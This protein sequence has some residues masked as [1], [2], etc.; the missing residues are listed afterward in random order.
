MKSLLVLQL[1]TE[2]EEL[3]QHL[4]TAKEAQE[5]LKSEVFIN[6]TQ[7]DYYNRLLEGLSVFPKSF[8]L[9]PSSDGIS[10]SNSLLIEIS[11][12]SVS[13]LPSVWESVSKHYQ[14]YYLKCP[15]YFPV[16]WRTILL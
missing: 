12:V 2:N 4:G 5:Q 3:N 8:K 9:T 13:F 7:E 6:G 10:L 1:S 15:Q 16:Q 11:T 14:V